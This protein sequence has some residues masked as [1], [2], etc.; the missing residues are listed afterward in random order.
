MN[1][2]ESVVARVL[3][4]IGDD[5]TYFTLLADLTTLRH[6]CRLALGADG[7][8]APSLAARYLDLP[9][10]AVSFYGAGEGLRTA[11]RALLADGEQCYALVGMEQLEQLRQVARI[12]NVIPEW[13][14]VY[15]GDPAAL[16]AGDAVPLTADDWTF[17]RELARRGGTTAFERNA[18]EKGPYFGVWRGA[19]L[20][21]M[22]G[23]HLKL[24]AAA[25][26]GNVVTDPAHRRRGW[27][28]M[29]VA[30]T[31]SALLAEGRD[32]FLQVYKSNTAAVRLYEK[33]GFERTRVL[34]LVRFVLRTC[35]A[36]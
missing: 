11:L 24:A 13:Q 4:E 30:A 17:M 14:M 31:A 19:R 9:F 25:E 6:R 1:V 10:A 35:P 22:A 21:S 8:A 7:S 3:T 5:L 23:T 32:V 34:Y 18:L 33:L 12:L 16:D 20:V 36:P 2:P 29:C 26:I 15:Q 27:A 28:T